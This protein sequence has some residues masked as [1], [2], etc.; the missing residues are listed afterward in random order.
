[1]N[2]CA[3]MANMFWCVNVGVHTTN[4]STVMEF[5]VLHLI[6]DTAAPDVGKIKV[7]C[8]IDKACTLDP[9]ERTTRTACWAEGLFCL[10]EHSQKC[11][12]TALRTTADYP[13]EQH[14]EKTCICNSSSSPKRSGMNGKVDFAN[15]CASK[16]KQYT[17]IC[18]C[19]SIDLQVSTTQLDVA[20]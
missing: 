4:L 10:A 3:K 16:S 1:M 13:T 20:L 15:K 14:F 7:G 19:F 5:A 8:T 18:E 17:M 6:W 12:L 11:S 2:I 9:D